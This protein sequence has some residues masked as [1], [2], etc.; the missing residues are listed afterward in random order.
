VT[1][2]RAAVRAVLV[3]GLWH[4][5]WSWDDVRSELDDAGVASAAVEL[6]MSSLEDDVAA[7][8]AE[9]DADP[10][11]AVLVGHSY[12]GAVITSAGTHPAV[13][14]LLYLAAFQLDAGESISRVLPER[15]IPPTELGSA[16]QF[17]ADGQQVGIDPARAPDLL[18]AQ[19]DAR[20]VA[21]ALDR[22]RPVAR[23][24]FAARPGEIAWQ[25][26]PSTYAVCTED[27]C[28]APDLQRAMAERA[29][30]RLEW[31]SDHSPSLS[32][33]QLVA[34]LIIRIARRPAPPPR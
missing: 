3:H 32:H 6:P 25:T 11:P 10:R 7:V 2:G 28:V 23:G 17:S 18:Y 21:T 16:L 34:D 26:L 19:S 22:L 31:A 33:P 1:A 4:G 15:A 14:H 9:L 24:L 8:R 12:G 5:A 13:R 20:T 29:G 27:R 30:E